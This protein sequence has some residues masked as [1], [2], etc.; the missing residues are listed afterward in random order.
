MIATPQRIL[1]AQTI[2]LGDLVLSLPLLHALHRAF[3][4]TAID[5]LIRAGLEDL[6]QDHPAISHIYT[7]DKRTAYRGVQGTLRLAHELRTGNHDVAIVLPG[8]VRTALAACLARI[9][10]RIG[11]DVGSG[12]LLF[13]DLLT[14][15][16]ELRRS[17][18]SW[19]LLP[20]ERFWRLF[21]PGTSVV[22]TLFTDV[23]KID[24]SLPAAARHLQLLAPLGIAP[25]P[26]EQL[27]F[28]ITVTDEHRCRIAEILGPHSASPLVGIAP[29]SRWATK[30]WPVRSFAQVARG[31][32][33][34][35][36]RVVVVGG[37][38]DRPLGVTIASAS[39]PAAVVNACGLL[40]LRS[41]VE[42]L[43][44]CSVLLTNDSAPAHLARAAGTP[45]ITLL[46]PTHTAFGFAH[47]DPPNLI[48]EAPDVACRPCTV[49]GGDRCPLGTHSC[50]TTIQPEHVLAM[51]LRFG[52][53]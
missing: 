27:E 23:V 18:G 29:G 38:E 52:V 36:K 39:G 8:S 5:L 4:D 21:S 3:P 34:A 50:M 2:Y 12:I 53:S 47:H 1:V 28:G 20:L 37:I 7:Y 51:A 49:H 17:P 48:A 41:T 10:V 9:P 24:R 31:L 11:T 14:F 30:Q 19:P 13:E 42:M 46:G 45:C 25:S 15:P 33:A 16:R 32:V 26:S 44:R 40:S 6:V 35:G 43:R 22:S